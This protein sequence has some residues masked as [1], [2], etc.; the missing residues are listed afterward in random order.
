MRVSRK[1]SISEQIRVVQKKRYSTFSFIKAASVE[2]FAA[3]ACT[4]A[5]YLSPYVE[6]RF[7]PFDIRA[8][9]RSFLQD[10]QEVCGHD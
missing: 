1:K 4:A 7:F 8:S 10:D 5:R 9:K 2:S 3:S 6:H